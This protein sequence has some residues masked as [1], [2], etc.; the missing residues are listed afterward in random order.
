[1]SVSGSAAPQQQLLVAAMVTGMLAAGAFVLSPLPVAAVVF[2]V[3]FAS[4]GVIACWLTGDRIFLAVGVLQVIYA[5]IVILGTLAASRKATALLQSQA[6]LAALTGP[7]LVGVA[8]DPL[9]SHDCGN[10]RY[11]AI[12]WLDACLSARLPRRIC[13]LLDTR[14]TPG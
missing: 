7:W 4:S 5:C 13:T 1:M 8:I 2:V 11:L 10:Q 6:N 12:P 14:D 3:I 9:S